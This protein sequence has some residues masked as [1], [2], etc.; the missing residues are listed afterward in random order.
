[1]SSRRPRKPVVVGDGSPDEAQHGIGGRVGLLGGPAEGAIRDVEEQ[2]AERVDHRLDALDQGQS[3]GDR[4][5]AQQQSARD[6]DDDY[7][8]SQL[9][10]HREVGEQ[11]REQE[12]VVERER[13]FDQV[14]RRPLAGRAG[15]EA[16]RRR[17]RHGEQEPTGGPGRCLAAARFAAWREQACLGA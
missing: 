7:A 3:G 6:A 2:H 5:A 11:Q 15:G 12:D 8:A 9:R 10:R 13:P 1:M 16:D 4:H 14:D 17:D